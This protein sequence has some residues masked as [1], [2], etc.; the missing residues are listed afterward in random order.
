M[1]ASAPSLALASCLLLATLL[2]PAPCLAGTVTPYKEYGTLD[3]SGKR[4]SYPQGVAV[5]AN[6]MIVVSDT[7][8][9]AIKAFTEDGKPAFAIA[10]NGTG[11]GQLS[12]PQGVAR[13][14][15]GHLWVADTNN[16]RLQEFDQEGNFVDQPGNPAG[17]YGNANEHRLANPYDL[18]VGP[19]GNYW[20]SDAGQHRIV[21][22]DKAGHQVRVIQKTVN[23]SVAG[24]ADGQFNYPT[25]ADFDGNGNLWV[26]DRNNSRLQQFAQDGTF[27]AKFGTN[28]STYGDTLSAPRAVYP[29]ADG[30]LVAHGNRVIKFDLNGLPLFTLG[31]TDNSSGSGNNEFNQAR[32]IAVDGGGNILVADYENH[33]IQKF[34]AS[35]TFVGAFGGYAAGAS[36]NPWDFDAGDIYH[37]VDINV[38]GDGNLW[39]LSQGWNNGVVQK[40]TTTGTYLSGFDGG[41]DGTAGVFSSP[42]DLTLS[43]DG[44]LWISEATG[45]RIR[46]YQAGGAWVQTIANVTID[47]Q[48]ATFSDPSG[49]VVSGNTAWVADYYNSRVLAVNLTDKSAQAFTGFS[50]PWGLAQDS[51]GDLWIADYNGNRVVQMAPSGLIKRAFSETAAQGTTLSSP[52]GVTADGMGGLWVSDPGNN[53]LLRFSAAGTLLAKIGGY[54]SGLVNDPEKIAVAADSSLW[55]A[56]YSGP[57]IWHFSAAGVCLGK[58]DNTT[59]SGV[60]L[61]GPTGVYLYHDPAKPANEYLL[62]SDRNQHQLLKFSS[63]GVFVGPLATGGSGSGLNQYYSPR[64]VAVS[65]QEVLLADYGNSRIKVMTPDG[66]YKLAYTTDGSDAQQFSSPSAVAYNAKDNTLWVADRNN[67]RLQVL[68]PDGAFIRTVGG[69]GN[70]LFGSVNDLHADTAGH[71]WFTAAA[72]DQLVELDGEGNLLTIIGSQKGDNAFGQP[73]AVLGMADG[74][75]WVT[76]TNNHRLAHLSGAGNLIVML[77][78]QIGN[79]DGQFKY[80]QGVAVST[81]GSTIYVADTENDRIQQFTKDGV[82]QKK[83]SGPGAGPG[84]VDNPAGLAVDGQGRLWVVERVNKRVQVF[85]ANGVKQFTKGSSALFN[86]PFGVAIDKSGKVWVTDSDNHRVLKFEADNS[87]TPLLAIG[88]TGKASGSGPGEF[89]TPMGIAVDS[90]G[91]IQ[92]ADTYNNRVQVFKEDG[93][94]LRAYGGLSSPQG[95]S[96]SNGKVVVADTGNNRVAVFLENGALVTTL[97]DNGAAEDGLN[98][99]QGVAQDSAGNLW[100]A[101]YGNNR[102]VRLDAAGKV[103]QKLTHLLNGPDGLAID[104]A[105]NLW[106]TSRNSHLLLKFSKTGALLKAFD[107]GGAAFDTINDPTAM[108]F[109]QNH[110]YLV[111]RANHRVVVLDDTGATVR[112]FG[113]Y[114]DTAGLL[115]DPWG[116]T[117]G[118]DNNLWVSQTYNEKITVFTPSG[119]FVKTFGSYGDQPGMLN[120]PHGLAFGLD[121]KL[122]VVNSGGHRVDCFTESGAYQKS[123]G[124]YGS[125]PGQLSW[126]QGVAI[127]S[128]GRLFVGDSSNHRISVFDQDG[129]FL[130][131]FGS[132]LLSNPMGMAIDQKGLLWVV[133]ASEYALLAFDLAGNLVFKGGE[134]GNGSGMMQAPSALAID[135]SGKAWVGDTSLDT[136]QAFEL[137]QPQG[138]ALQLTHRHWRHGAESQHL[139]DAPVGATITPQVQGNITLGATTGTGDLKSILATTWLSSNTEVATV[140]ANGEIT[141]K[142]VG[143][144]EI[145]ATISGQALT[146]NVTVVADNTLPVMVL[147]NQGGGLGE[148]AYPGPLWGGTVAG[149]GRVYAA[150]SNNGRITVLDLQGN[151]LKTITAPGYLNNIGGLVV[152]K[153]GILYV[154]DDNNSKIHKFDADGH[155]LLSMG[156]Y[157]NAA[158]QLN[159]PQGLALD[160]AGNLWVVDASNYR[161][162]KFSPAG[163]LLGGFGSWG[164]DVDKLFSNLTDVAIDGAGSLWVADDTHLKKFKADGTFL[165]KAPEVYPRRLWLDQSGAIWVRA[166]DSHILKYSPD[167]SLLMDYGATTNQQEPGMFN[168]VDGIAVD[169]SGALWVAEGSN[170]RLQRIRF[171]TQQLALMTDKTVIKDQGQVNAVVTYGVTPTVTP[172][173]IVNS[174]A[175]WSVA[176]AEMAQ[177]GA[178]LITANETGP[179]QVTAEFAGLSETLDLNLLALYAVEQSGNVDMASAEPL[180][181]GQ[182]LEGSFGGNDYEEHWFAITPAS[183]GYYRI[184]HSTGT[185]ESNN[186]L[187]ILDGQGETIHAINTLPGSGLSVPIYLMGQTTYYVHLSGYSPEEFML[188]Y[189]FSAAGAPPSPANSAAITLGEPVSG[190]VAIASSNYYKLV[191]NGPRQL[192]FSYETPGSV[193]DMQISVY[194]EEVSEETVL[195]RATSSNG[196]AKQIAIGLNQGTYYIEM[197]TIGNIDDLPYTLTVAPNLQVAA[198]EYEGNNT[199]AFANNLSDGVMVAARN[200]SPQDVDLYTFHYAPASAQ[201]YLTLTFTQ[202]D[203]NGNHTIRLRNP[204]GNELKS[205]TVSNWQ[206]LLPQKVNMKPGQYFLEVRDSSDKRTE[207]QLTLAA[208]ASKISAVKKVTG[209]ELIPAKPVAEI[210][211]GDTVAITARVYYS[212]GSVVEN[213]GEA[214]WTGTNPEAI[215]VTPGQ[216]AV[217][218]QGAG[219]V[220]VSFEGKVATMELDFSFGE[221]KKQNFGNLIIVAGGGIEAGNKLKEITQYLTDL[222]YLKFKGRGF[223]DDDILYFNPKEFKDLDGNGFNDGI[224]D[225][226]EVTKVEFAKAISE[227][228]TNY[229]ST[230]PLY[231]YLND[232]G[233]NA[234]F[235]LYPNQIL[236]AAMLKDLLDTFQAATNRA[237]VVVIEACHSGT[238]VAPLMAGAS[239]RVVITSSDQGVAFLGDGGSASF[240]QF[241]MGSLYKGASLS[242]AY[243]DANAAL[244]ALGM[245]YTGMYP[246]VAPTGLASTADDFF[247]VGNFALAPMFPEISQ[248]QL[249]ATYDASSSGGY[250]IQAKVTGVD[251]GKVWATVKPVNYT[252]PA[253]SGEF[254]TPDIQLP[255]VDLLDAKP[256][257]PDKA[258]DGVFNGTYSGFT[259]NG[260]Y[261]VVIFARDSEG[262]ITQTAVHKLTVTGLSSSNAYLNA[263]AGWSLLSSLIPFQ[264]GAHLADQQKFTSAWKWEGGTWAVYLAGEGQPGAYAAS[265]GFANFT[266]INPGEGFWV[267]SKSDQQVTITGTPALGELTFAPGWNLLGLKSTGASTVAE[268]ITGQSGIVSI[269]KWENGTWAVSLPSEGNP[270]A[271]AQSKGFNDLVTINPGEGFWVNKQ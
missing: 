270:G 257:D 220:V 167:L 109:W 132:S 140:A 153:D 39:V 177:V 48:A 256:D 187:T 194:P 186:S 218:K 228:A 215:T 22:L 245:P 46:E 195:D 124:S 15:Q 160:Q 108:A 102:V 240:S 20:I 172:S 260:D 24:D 253:V 38:D 99:P 71:I 247:V 271:Y 225:Q 88:K 180:A 149:K 125:E 107:N 103:A 119:D 234:Q 57:S 265:K 266:A 61:D 170:H 95:L 114:G 127:D 42:E 32:G 263:G 8:N 166:S 258:M 27:K 131:T 120:D 235:Q 173:E 81:D 213:P 66:A 205:Y 250:A 112:T 91:N 231:I 214:S 189:I 255:M 70:G 216:V 141:A 221:V 83:I 152:D 26:A 196:E 77:G 53:R 223:G 40:F 116:I 156:E 52:N 146:M 129:T 14:S 126:P 226:Q 37:P 165:A 150:D 50:N 84:F 34:T 130:Y 43:V 62:V 94:F 87:A 242:E 41:S 207:Y 1:K 210:K 175:Q 135:G 85:D 251:N 97:S 12:Y 236:T 133:D 89:N 30:V 121:G 64:G 98:D 74:S 208:K 21:V 11:A 159:S 259:G 13:D 56:D 33:R 58:I 123:I 128:Q 31:K 100:V 217:A 18:K 10:N 227:W 224:V 80:P 136:L 176:P 75:V 262:N 203:T 96:I 4:F 113:A 229:P 93:T 158:G 246:Q 145:T 29:L 73:A 241:F 201:D 137:S 261:D 212:D 243:A 76:D 63:S 204:E 206:P 188:A 193:T 200:Y 267:N 67:D 65:G 254:A 233:A 237:V 7:N 164:W 190:Q 199:L 169:G 82:F 5:A 157:G 144:A 161:L 122:W 134:Y 23:S 68:N 138:L 45:N 232:H 118:P 239:K 115:H 143:Q 249:A 184:L 238:F 35:G 211:V 192:L 181:A 59:Q 198:G 16:H 264:V 197:K 163:A 178:G 6:G 90:E 191:L 19:D 110:L 2:P 28:G 147:G 244:N 222:A 49:I 106:V 47:G 171:I 44:H 182:A 111:D 101:D 248:P 268:L 9:H 17:S 168:G 60:T 69:P 183:D 105:D 55:V 179:V 151:W 174:Q 185:N 54:Y 36:L 148:Y 104:S 155:Y 139:L 78:G 86:N 92:V 72:Q 202:Q 154:S 117:V 3:G 209:V 269:W 252:P 79:G 162:Q 219:S 142:A 51:G 230:G 25:G